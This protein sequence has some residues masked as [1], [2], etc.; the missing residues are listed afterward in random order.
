MQDINR[1][2][3]LIEF[4]TRTIAGHVIEFHTTPVPAELEM[5]MEQTYTKGLSELG[6]PEMVITGMNEEICIQRLL[7]MIEAAGSEAGLSI[8][9][10]VEVVPG[11]K[12]V[13]QRCQPTEEFDVLNNDT[14]PE[15]AEANHTY[16][17]VLWSDAEAKFPGDVE[18][19]QPTFPQFVY[20][21][22]ATKSEKVDEVREI[23]TQRIAENGYT[24]MGVLGDADGHR[25]CYSMTSRE[26]HPEL[27]CAIG[28]AAEGVPMA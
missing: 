4:T 23:I 9:Q 10:L 2:E 20:K 12:K 5:E 3:E 21:R 16:L 19:L 22:A 8:D 6:L 15:D 25:F 28:M 18:Y 13:V 24:M 26:L 27:L 17:Q 1:E 14:D 11:N 7:I